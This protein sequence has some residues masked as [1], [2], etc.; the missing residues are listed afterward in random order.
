M[1]W[2]KM[3]LR[4]KEL[5]KIEES[6]RVRPYLVVRKT[7][8]ML[9]CYQS[10]SKPS[11]ILN[12]YEEYYIKKE[13]YKKKKDSFLNFT[14]AIMLPI[15]NI[16][17]M[18]ITLNDFDLKE[19]EKRLQI[20]ENRENKNV[21]R[22]YINIEIGK[23]DVVLYNKE[24][25][26]IYA[27]DNS[28]VYGIKIH[29]RNTYKQDNDKIFVNRKTYYIIHNNMKKVAIKRIANLQIIDTAYK[30]EIEKINIIKNRKKEKKEQEKIKRQ[31]FCNESIKEIKV[32]TVFKVG[33]SKILYLFNKEN[34]YYG[35]DII[36]YII[37]PRIIEIK[38]ITKRRILEVKSKEE[39]LKYIEVLL[40]NDNNSC[41][42]LKKLYKELKV[43]IYK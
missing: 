23:G 37:A 32:G 21:E 2:A 39:C 7:K 4:K 42:K 35:V 9:I 41:K 17:N 6:H 10:S 43:S 1:I 27:A 28:Y 25:Y 34:K 14:K 13:K 3:P 15:C 36:Y 20:L 18:Y 22:F 12:N 29:K 40:K 38:S 5:R 11:V 26:Y 33:N 8:N 19:I 30:D 24:I 16:E 31:V